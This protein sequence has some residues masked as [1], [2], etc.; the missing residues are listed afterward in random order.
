MSSSLQDQLL[1]AGLVDKAKAKDVKKTK[2]KQSKQKFKQKKQVDD[3][4]K[5]TSQRAHLEKVE[6]DRELNRQKSEQAKQK[7]IHSQIKQ[8][9]T[10]NMITAREADIAYN[11]TDGSIVQKLYV[12]SE[13]QKQ[14]IKGK[15]VIVKLEEHYHIIPTIVADKIAMRDDSYLVHQAAAENTEAD[16]DDPYADYQVPDDLMW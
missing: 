11:F 8:L 15:L 3:E 13:T 5:L 12:T 14:L 16:A 1:K 9:I 4:I 7:E 10:L 6:K 2:Q